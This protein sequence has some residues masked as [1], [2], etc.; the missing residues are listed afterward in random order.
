MTYLPV[1]YNNI[2]FIEF[3]PLAYKIN[4]VARFLPLGC[5][6]TQNLAGDNC[7]TAWQSRPSTIYISRKRLCFGEANINSI[8]IRYIECIH[9]WHLKSVGA[10]QY[11]SKNLAQMLMQGLSKWIEVLNNTSHG[12]LPPGGFHLF[13]LTKRFPITLSP[14]YICIDKTVPGLL[15]VT[16]FLSCYFRIF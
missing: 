1:H 13:S 15:D 11:C 14:I 2:S 9:N 12:L 3:L 7:S 10:R 16:R 5:F 8:L 4:H 6:D